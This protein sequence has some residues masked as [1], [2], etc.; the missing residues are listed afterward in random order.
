MRPAPGS[1]SDGSRR[2][3]RPR[4]SASWARRRCASTA[5]TSRSAPGRVGAR[6]PAARNI[7]PARC[8]AMSDLQTTTV[9]DVIGDDRWAAN[10]IAGLAPASCRLYALILYRFTEGA[11]PDRDEL[12][13]L[14]FGGE[15]LL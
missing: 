13:D 10:R 15:A 6:S 3:R 11:P 1:S 4:R 9:T 8:E 5:S 2:T 14:G 7:E 12:S